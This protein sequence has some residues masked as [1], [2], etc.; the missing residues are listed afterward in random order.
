MMERRNSNAPPDL[1]GQADAIVK[2]RSALAS[3]SRAFLSANV[4]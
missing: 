2:V 1:F 4:R 3:A